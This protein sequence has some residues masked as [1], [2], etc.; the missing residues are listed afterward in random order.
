MVSRASPCS[1]HRIFS[2]LARDRIHP[3]LERPRLLHHLQVRTLFCYRGTVIG[4]G[5]GW[6]LGA[7]IAGREL[8]S[9]AVFACEDS[10]Y[11]F[12]RYIDVFTATIKPCGKGDGLIAQIQFMDSLGMDIQHDLAIVRVASRYF[13]ARLHHIHG[14]LWGKPGI[15]RPLMQGTNQVWPCGALRHARLFTT[16]P[17]FALGLGQT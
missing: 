9:A 5:R 10:K 16:R 13:N 17:H 12:H 3:R 6:R 14:N 4:D 2:L 8:N 15:Q 7:L 11:G 1:H